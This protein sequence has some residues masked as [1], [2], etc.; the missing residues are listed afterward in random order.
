MHVPI[1]DSI[2]YSVGSELFNNS[3]VAGSIET[4]RT[5]QGELSEQ[6]FLNSSGNFSSYT[7]A[8]YNWKILPE[9][10]KP[11]EV[12]EIRQYCPN[13]RNRI[14]KQSWKFCPGCGEQL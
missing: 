5:E 3:Q 6:T 7:T 13:C 1:N 12:S 11:V 14:R 8:E 10:V 4:G 2:S 9:S